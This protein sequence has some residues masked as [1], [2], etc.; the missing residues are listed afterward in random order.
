MVAGDRHQRSAVGPQPAHR[1][2]GHPE[3]PV[4]RPGMIEDV[5]QPQHDVGLEGEGEVD[6]GL[7]GLLEVALPLIGAVGRG[8]R[9]V[10]PPEM[11]VTQ[12]YD[13]CHGTDPSPC[14]NDMRVTL[15]RGYDT[16]TAMQ[17]RGRP[18][19]KMVGACS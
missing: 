15:H 2:L 13:P 5:A 7:E 9:V 17:G 14:E 4:A 1:P 6:G 10:L 12:G 18:G 16:H 11:S 3:G 8:A 19:L